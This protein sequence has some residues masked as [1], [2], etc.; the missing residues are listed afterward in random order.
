MPKAISNAP[1]NFPFAPWDRGVGG[2]SAATEPSGAAGITI[3]ATMYSTIPVPPNSV[4]STQTM[5][6][7][8]TS[9]PRYSAMPPQT[10]SI[11]RS[12]RDL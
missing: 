10:P 1:Q 3:I 9:S 5:R 8:V 12:V 2:L 7:R 6:M 4:S 11:M